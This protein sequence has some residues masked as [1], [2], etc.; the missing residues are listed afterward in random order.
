MKVCFARLICA[1]CNCSSTLRIAHL[2]FKSR[3]REGGKGLVRKCL[4]TGKGTNLGH[5][6]SLERWGLIPDFFLKIK[7]FRGLL[8]T[9]VIRGDGSVRAFWSST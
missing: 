8:R 9:L 3:L 4:Y 6:V 7:Y 5:F 2:G 1:I